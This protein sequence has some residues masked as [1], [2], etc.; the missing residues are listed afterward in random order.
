MADFYSLTVGDLKP[1]ER[2][3][4][5]SAENLI[6]AIN[7]K[8]N[9]RLE[10]FLIGLGIR[11]IGEE[12]ALL[13]AQQLR[14]KNEE[15]RIKKLLDNILKLSKDDLLKIEDFGPIVARSVYDWFRC[16]RNIKLLDKLEQAGIVIDI[17]H[18]K[19]AKKSLKFSG[20]TVVLTGSLKSLT[21]EQ[22][23][24]KIRELGGKISSAVSQK[25]DLVLAGSDPGSKFDKA[26]SLGIKVV[27][28][29]E[30]MR[31]I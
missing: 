6:E 23:K 27:E 21:R 28:E 11:H 17:S 1:L 18:L 2:F 24:A 30:F 5:K 29:D 31:M 26:K 3:A 4:E 9:I 13:L 20:K 14:I 15:L 10:R 16:K 7:N 8:K 22:A 12:S 25:T 19:T